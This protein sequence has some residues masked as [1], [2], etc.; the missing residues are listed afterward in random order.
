MKRIIIC[1]DGTWNDPDQVD[2]QTKRRRPTN[3]TKV[4]RA[5]LPKDPNNDIEQVVYYHDGV[6]TSGGLDKF[7]GG[8][9]GRHRAKYT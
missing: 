7:T 9:F 5:V 6:G 8:A 2:N 3:V 1:A 4:A